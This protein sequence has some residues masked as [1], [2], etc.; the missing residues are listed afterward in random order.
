MAKIEIDI[1]AKRIQETFK[2]F[3]DARTNW[4]NQARE[5]L[6]F[7]LGNHY[8]TQEAS[9]LQS[10]SQADI[11]ID[12]IYPA[13]EQLKSI[14]TARPP[15]FSVVA[16]ED[17]DNKV[18]EVWKHILEYI[19][20]ISDGNE[21]FKQVVHDYAITGLGYLYAYLDRE[22]DFGRGEIKFQPVSPFRVYVDPN[23]RNKWFDDASEIFVSTIL[24]E[25][26]IINLYPKLNEPIPE[27]PEKRLIDKV[28][29]NFYKDEDFPSSTQSVKKNTFTP[30]EVKDY[31]WG[32]QGSTKY[33]LI[34]Q[35]SK[36]KVPYY[37]VVMVMPPQ[38]EGQQPQIQQ[39]VMRPQEFE[40][41]VKDPQIAELSK[42][43]RVDVE[44]IMQTRIKVTCALG[45]MVLY[46]N[47]LDTNK[48]P[49]VPFPN[50]WT[51]TPYPI[52]DVAKVKD[53]QKFINKMFSL[54]I[55]HAQTSAGLKLLVPQGSIP[56]MEQLEKDWANP[57]AT[58]EYDASMGEPH[59]PQPQPLP[60]SFYTLM[61]QGEHYIDL[62]LGIFEMQQGNPDA[63]P[64]TSSGTMMME[65]FGQR[66][67][68]SK[69]RDIEGSLK[70][71]GQVI[72]SLAKTHYNFEKKIRIVQPNNDL[73]EYTINRRLV[74]DKTGTLQGIENDITSGQFDV[75]VI[76]NSTLP[77]NRYGELDVY[78]M[79]YQS[80]L[81]DRTEVL[82]KTDIFDKEG[83]MQRIDLVQQLQQQVEQQTKVI[84]ELEGDLQTA[85]REAVSARQRT[86][87]EKFKGT[88]QEE[89]NKEK[90]RTLKSLSKL[91]TAVN[92]ASEKSRMELQSGLT[93]ENEVEELQ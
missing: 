90:E 39:R 47:I 43:G 37:R 15:K 58:I 59:F 21:S 16:R 19:W 22:A 11:V 84:K 2:R 67:S 73:T 79:A 48:Y 75:R 62:N 3:S 78:M 56:D 64:K 31:D 10:R 40:Q 23:S 36:V 29:D 24:T 57:N 42:L 34:E 85:R 83:V 76:G 26:Q 46:E 68:K 12:R 80:G 45:Q 17:S 44:E 13:I 74:D 63:A 8:T 9:E 53:V 52:G 87:V 66:R 77:S 41:F 49:I 32:K 86:E 35:F 7:Y 38:E 54:I 51:N 92:L 89:K 30:S 1:R 88:M 25:D 55:S 61:Q 28:E 5:D 72:H 20:D 14:L 6:D 91:E 71:L 33:R 93:Q 82:K 81:I 4:D 70:R 18:S 65:D 60:T 69:L 27:E 50:V